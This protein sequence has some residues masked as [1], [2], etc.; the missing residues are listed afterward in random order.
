MIVTLDLG[1][2]NSAYCVGRPPVAAH[3]GLYSTCFNSVLRSVGLSLGC[4]PRFVLVNCD[5]SGFTL[6]QTYDG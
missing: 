1:A 5:R 6:S 4:W 3:I 2:K